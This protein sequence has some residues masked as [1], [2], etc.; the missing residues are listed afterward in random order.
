MK[1]GTI[2]TERPTVKIHT[3]NFNLTNLNY[4]IFVVIINV[5]NLVDYILIPHQGSLHKT[6]YLPNLGLCD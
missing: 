2:K 3:D 1:K 5:Y 6:G 4:V